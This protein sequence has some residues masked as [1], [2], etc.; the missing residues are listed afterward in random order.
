MY[1]GFGFLATCTS[2]DVLFYKFSKSR[3]FILFAY[4][5]PSV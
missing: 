1:V 2:F 4:K 5:F 3:A